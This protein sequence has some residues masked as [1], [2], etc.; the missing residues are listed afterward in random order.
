[1]NYNHTITVGIPV[2]NEGLN[3]ERLLKSIYLQKSKKIRIREIIVT[4]DGSSDDT[5]EKAVHSAQ[6]SIKLIVIDNKD[7]KGISRGL[8]Q[9]I[10]RSRTDVLVTLDG[11]IQIRDSFFIEKLVEPIISGKADFTSSATAELKPVSSVAKALAVSM[12]IK[13]GLFSSFADGNNLYTCFGLARGYSKKFYQRLNFK[14][15]VG[16]DMYSY[17]SCLSLGLT[18]VHA[19]KA[20]AYYRVPE[21]FIDNCHYTQAAF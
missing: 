17:L 15:S 10:K 11:D 12:K 6:K 9:I 14:V 13:R 4:S 7:R 16:N 3:I 5:V 8:N 20:T 21:T 2:Y 19:K 1:M 18:F